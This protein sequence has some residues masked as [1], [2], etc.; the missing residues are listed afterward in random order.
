M[1]GIDLVELR[2]LKVQ[3]ISIELSLSLGSKSLPKPFFHGP[4]TF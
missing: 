1:T 4:I 3:Q 2:D